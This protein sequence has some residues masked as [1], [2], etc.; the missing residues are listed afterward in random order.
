M[1]GRSEKKLKISVLGFGHWGKNILRNLHELGVLHSACDINQEVVDIYKKRYP[2]V[3]FTVF[4]D[5]IFE[6]DE[7]DAICIA[8]PAST[9]YKIAKKAL[10]FGKDVFVEKPLAL[11]V[12]EAQEIIEVAREKGKIVMVGHILRYHPAVRK[13]KE[14]VSGGELG[15]I[16]YIYSNRLNIGR[17]RTEENILWSFA[18]HDISLTLYIVGEEPEKIDAFG[19]YYLTEGLFDTTLTV[20]DFPNG[21]KAHI[22]VSWLHPFKEQKFV[23]VGSE[24]MV[25]FDDLKE[26]KLFIYPHKIMWKEGKIPVAH[27][28]DFYTVPVEKKEPLKEELKHF[29][30]CVKKRQK[31]ETDAEEGLRVLKILNIAQMKLEEKYGRGDRPK[32]YIRRDYHGAHELIERD[33]YFFHPSSFIDEG[34]KIGKGTK[35]WHFS[36]IMKGAEIGEGCII[37]QNVFIG[38]D[39]R[40]GK[41]CKI[42]NNVSIFKGVELEDGVFCGPSATFTNVYNPR[43]FVERKHEFM[44]TK[45]GRG[46]TIGANATVVCGVRIGKFAVVGA[47]AVV[48]KDVP[49]FAVVVGVPARQIGWAC[50]C[51]TT[52]KFDGK[53][54]VCEYCGAEFR[55]EGKTEEKIKLVKKGKVDF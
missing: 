39:V 24:K 2:D 44:K 12:E 10:E 55:K 42:Q 17:L 8:T 21:V 52:L 6:D 38:Q 16:Y 40:I 11:H 46:A 45:V 33:G 14:M 20:L 13:L 3:R 30:E 49:D 31:P 53:K 25:V 1:S 23:V 47:G 54:A 26:E 19:G 22:F 41:R 35:I 36:H 37:G 50:I 27:K 32:Q 4:P 5:D 29:I 51:G 7:V 28:A 18:P 15:K 9:H 34:V 43:A 48:K